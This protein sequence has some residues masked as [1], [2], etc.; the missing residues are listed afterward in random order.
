MKILIFIEGTILMH[1]SAQ[2][3]SRKEIVK[4]SRSAGI[5]REERSVA[6]D[7]GIEAPKVPPGSVYDLNNYMP[8]GQ[9]N[10]KLQSWAD[11]G[12][13]IMYLSSRRIKSELDMIQLVLKKYHFPQTENFY[14]RQ[15]GEDYRDV[16]ERLLPD[17]L[18]EDDCESIGGEKEMTFTHIKSELKQKIKHITI[19]EFGGVDHLPDNIKK[20]AL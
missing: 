16:A 6:Y 19:K 11:Q 4:Q 13:Q 17:V 18:I 12:A 2:G 7:S 20:L 8:I 14:F 10:K 9:A 3:L 5:Q 15:Q 1:Q